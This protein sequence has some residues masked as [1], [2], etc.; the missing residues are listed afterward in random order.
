M[1]DNREYSLDSTT[2][3]IGDVSIDQIEG[4]VLFRIW[5]VNQVGIVQ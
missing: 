5:P 2:A 1:G 4:K 3:S